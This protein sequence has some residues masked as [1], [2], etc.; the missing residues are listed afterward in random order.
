[1]STEGL[2]IPGTSQKK[3]PKNKKGTSYPMS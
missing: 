1:V 3:T 2:G